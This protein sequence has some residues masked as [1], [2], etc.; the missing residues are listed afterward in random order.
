MAHSK[1]VEELGGL[2]RVDTVREL[3]EGDEC[4]GEDW[5]RGPRTPRA[6]GV[7]C[8]VYA[9]CG[10]IP[11]A[12]ELVLARHSMEDFV[13]GLE[14]KFVPPVMDECASGQQ[15]RGSGFER[16]TA[17]AVRVSA[18]LGIDTYTMD[19]LRNVIDVVR[20]R[21]YADGTNGRGK[22]MNRGL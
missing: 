17:A 6:A 3:V 22:L 11:K 16:W 2:A 5:E 9:L 12:E 4:D 14:G 21:R 1:L 20:A 13:G 18:R 7:L 19:Q 8:D 10:E 15:R